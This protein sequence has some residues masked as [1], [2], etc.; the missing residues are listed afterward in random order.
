ML[1]GTRRRPVPAWDF[2]H[3]EIQDAPLK[4]GDMVHLE[5]TP[6][7]EGYGAR[8]MRCVSVGPVDAARQ[9]AAAAL[10]LLQDRQ[11]AAMRAGAIAADVDAI[12]RQGVVREGLWPSYG[13]ITGYTLGL[14]APQT[15][16]TSDF[17]RILHPE[18]AWKLEA[19]MVFHVYASAVG[20]ALSETVLVTEGAAERLTGTARGILFGG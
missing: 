8:I 6:R 15:P 20:V 9:Q 4:P 10:A 16:R 19:G 1:C 17:T 3:G 11:I 14:Y 12:L 13:N 18:A 2:L 5:L 7:V